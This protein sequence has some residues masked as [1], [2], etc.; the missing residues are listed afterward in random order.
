V[1]NGSLVKTNKGHLYVSVALG[2]ATI[3]NITV[4]ALS[5]QSPLGSLLVGLS[6]KGVAEINGNV[7]VVEGIE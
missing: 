7:Y 4:T 3:E 1:V 6:I 2:R 5:P